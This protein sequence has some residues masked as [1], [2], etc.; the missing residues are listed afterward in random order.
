M[1]TS[2]IVMMTVICG[3]VWGGFISCI[4]F[5]VRREKAKAA[6]REIT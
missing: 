4:V 3:L 6:R 2:A 5:V 1:S